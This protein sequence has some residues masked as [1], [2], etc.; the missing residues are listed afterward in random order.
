MSTPP[1]GPP[2]ARLNGQQ[3]DAMS[4]ASDTRLDDMARQVQSLEAALKRQQFDGPTNTMVTEMMQKQ[5]KLMETALA[6]KDGPPKSLMNLDVHFRS[7]S[8]MT[9]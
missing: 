3:S 6:K 2:G 8:T 9:V 4:N 1:V 7:L 5:L